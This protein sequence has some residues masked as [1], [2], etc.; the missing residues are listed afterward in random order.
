MVDEV[1]RISKL[2]DRPGLVIA[3]EVDESGYPILLHCLAA[4]GTHGEVHIDLGGVEFCDLAGLRA[5]VCVGRPDEPVSPGRHVC[6]HAVPLGLRKILQILGWD[7][8][9][10]LAFDEASLAAGPAP[11]CLGAPTPHE[12][13]PVIG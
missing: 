7:Q 12:E 11:E 10:E 6:L 5:I 2:N 1:L 8:A 13:R 3:G 4:L 9:P